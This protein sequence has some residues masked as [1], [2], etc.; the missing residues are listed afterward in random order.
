MKILHISAS[1]ANE[2]LHAY[3]FHFKKTC[4]KLGYDIISLSPYTDGWI[5]K[6]IDY[7]FGKENFRDFYVGKKLF[8]LSRVLYNYPDRDFIFIENCKFPFDNDVDIPVI[9]YHR[10]L[11]CKIYVKNPDFFLVRFTSAQKTRDGRPK[12][13]QPE[14][15]E[16][17]HPEIW[18]NDKIKKIWHANAIS[19]D[20][21]N[22]FEEFNSYRRVKKGW[23]Y[24]GSYKPVEEMM[25]FNSF[26]YF[27]Y[28]KHLEIINFIEKHNLAAEFRVV[29]PELNEYKQHLYQFDATLVIPAWDSWETRRLYEASYCKCVPILYIQNKNARRV[30]EMQGYVHGETC[31][32]FKDKESLLNLNIYDYDLDAIREKAYELVI[33]NHTYE[34]RVKELFEKI[35]VNNIVLHNTLNR[36]INSGSNNL[37]NILANLEAINK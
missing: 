10:D 18:Y 16:Q 24:Y 19:Q 36:F 12:G 14:I 7:R 37:N 34:A 13:G 11:N 4:K 2:A 9:Y 1:H 26:H 32:T 25:Q 3:S 33:K 8:P 15:I 30:F 23:A 6:D 21:F 17:Y 22:E 27:V 20:E 31:I 29:N 28:H 5:T 35:D